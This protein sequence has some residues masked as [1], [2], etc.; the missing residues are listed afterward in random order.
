MTNFN[1]TVSYNDT[2]LTYFYYI[3]QFTIETDN[4]GLVWAYKKGRSRTC[5]YLNMFLESINYVAMM[6]SVNLYI[7]H[8]NRKT[9][10]D[11]A[12]ADALTRDDK[13]METILLTTK[14]ENQFFNFPD[15]LNDWMD[16]PYVAESFPFDFYRAIQYEN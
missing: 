15:L 16:A 12:C 5:P 2:N 14:Q 9:T 8:V 1:Y 10:Q 7:R 11:S 3:L 4:S 6:Y 13:D